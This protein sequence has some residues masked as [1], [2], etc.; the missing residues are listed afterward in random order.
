MDSVTIT[1][2][3]SDLRGENIRFKHLVHQMIKEKP[4][5]T[6][7]LKDG[8]AKDGI[9]MYFIKNENILALL[10]KARD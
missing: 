4:N 10:E 6:Y 7:Q 9:G 5:F 8:V 2:L 3:T 1:E